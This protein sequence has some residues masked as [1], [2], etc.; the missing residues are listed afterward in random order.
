[1]SGSGTTS[2]PTRVIFAKTGND[3]RELE[4]KWALRPALASI[5]HDVLDEVGWQNCALF[6]EAVAKVA[7]A[8]RL[9]LQLF[10]KRSRFIIAQ[11]DDYIRRRKS[12]AIAEAIKKFPVDIIGANWD[13][14]SRDGASAHFRGGLEYSAFQRETAQSL[15]SVNMNPNVELGV[16]DRFFTALSAGVVPITDTN[17]F[18]MTNFPMLYPYTFNFDDRSVEAA[19]ERVFARPGEALEIASIAR[20]AAAAASLSTEQ[21]AR[22]IMQ[23]AELIDYFEYVF[24]SPQNYF[25]P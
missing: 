24:E 11:V 3:P 18:T 25:I 5:I 20:D 23:C 16:H 14:I 17:S 7:S 19:V 9:E 12:T 21:A 22:E 1:V 2:I 13:H 4:T 10:D 6:P 15:A 8:H